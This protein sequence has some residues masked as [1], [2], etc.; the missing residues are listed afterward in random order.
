MKKLFGWFF[1]NMLAIATLFLLAFIP[2]Y[3][4][5]PLVDVVGT[6]VY[7]RSEDFVVFIVL[8]LWVVALFR[9]KISL[10]TPLTMP[11]FLFWI[12]G[13]IATLHGVLLIFPT[14]QDVYQNVAFLS[15]LRRIEYT[16]IFFVAFSATQGKRYIRQIIAVL[17]ITLFMVAA[18]GI[19]Q[20]YLGF[21]AFL[22]MNEEFA[23]GWAIR[24]SP[25]SRISS[26][27]GGHYDFA[28]YL[29][30]VVP[31]IVS[32]LF[33]LRH[34]LLRG[35]LILLVLLSGIA[36]FMT[37]SRISF[38]ALIAAI[39]LVL[40]FHKRKLVVLALPVVALAAVVILI[41]S[42]TLLSRF[43]STIKE[44]DVI[45]DAKTQR[46][47][48]HPQDVPNTYFADKVIHQQ[49]L[50]DVSDVSLTASPSADIV[51]P[52]DNLP[53]SVVLLTQPS[54]PT[55]E[56]L[57]QG[58]GYI[59]ISLSPIKR[60]IGNFYY[61]PT[62][63]VPDRNA[64]VFIINGSFLVKRVLTYDLSFT[65]RF[66]GGWPRTLAAFKRNVFLGSGY[67][68]VGLAVDNSYLR[69]LGETGALGFASFLGIFLIMAMVIRKTF[70]TL[71]DPLERSFIVGFCAGLAGLAFNGLFIDVF[72]ASKV[73]FVLW[74]LAGIVMGILLS[75]RDSTVSLVKE[76]RSVIASPVAI[77]LS[78]FVLTILIYSPLLQ[79]GFVGD[80]FTWFR[81]VSDCGA[82]Q[83]V[84]R[85]LPAVSTIQEFFTNASGFFYRPGAKVYFLLMYWLFWLN[86]NAYHLVSLLL[87]FFVSTLIFF[88]ARKIL[89]TLLLS[90]AVAFFFLLSSGAIEAVH[91]ISATGFLWATVFS[92]LSLVSFISWQENR[93]AVLL[94]GSVF[95]FS[96]SLLFHEL[97]IVTPFLYL[98]YILIYRGT[99]PKVLFAPIPVYLIARFFAQSHWFSGDY[100]YNLLKLPF[101][102]VGNSVGYFSL[103]LFGP[104]T[105]PA[106]FALR[107]L[108]KDNIL[109]AVIVLPIILFVIFYT[110]KLF[111][112]FIKTE[113][114]KLFL[115]GLLL[116][117][118]SLL[119]F[120][121]LGNMASRYGYIA[122]IGLMFMLVVFLK[123][124][125]ASLL[126]NGRTIS[127]AALTITISIFSLF[128][129]IQQQQLHSDWYEAGEKTKRFLDSIAAYYEDDWATR[130]M[131]IHLVNVPIRLGQA[132]VFPVGIDDALYLIFRNPQMKVYKWPSLSGAFDYISDDSPT[133]KVFMFGREGSV[134]EQK[135]IKTTQ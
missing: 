55:G 33:V 67:G 89:K 105:T 13:A 109:V 102:A 29:V 32:V 60:R 73:A 38:L 26:T 120:L 58:T 15:F 3:P 21:P 108:L 112:Q 23:K 106:Y 125:Y 64:P 1:D 85:C 14:L 72:E 24:L 12:V 52:Y 74:I 71:T 91:W 84:Q 11:I 28:A 63:G 16:S 104:A 2:L 62:K 100:N 5:L 75:R 114:R 99:F 95:F 34:W 122:S 90:A 115:F 94:F 7:V 36:M 88:L 87:H 66:Q 35:A 41:A 134:T 31:V 30:L 8:F 113:D 22:T 47:V 80:D 110:G 86:Q 96:F 107:S 50:A 123:Y 10:K 98:A 51:I 124:L 27:F 127:L 130:P 131:E 65:T 93:K 116:F 53:A 135:K 45:V 69:T 121:G 44:I 48:G 19:G 46:V 20:K 57:P 82:S 118:V 126:V 97:G 18:Y 103:A 17:A 40:L 79:N 61:E 92:L 129:I 56:D 81:W 68:S 4:K 6:W 128:Q 42:P 78:L 43:G 49:F 37:V 119:P 132:W 117:L 25:L 133:Q 83:I 70:P 76:L 77:V 9:N 39:G 111:L 101:N 54:A 59:N